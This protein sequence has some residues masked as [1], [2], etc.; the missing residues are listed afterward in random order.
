MVRKESKKLAQQRGR[1]GPLFF[2]SDTSQSPWGCGVWSAGVGSCCGIVNRS[3]ASQI[4]E[5]R[6]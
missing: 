3:L 4:F 2:Y 1:E 5:S 6:E